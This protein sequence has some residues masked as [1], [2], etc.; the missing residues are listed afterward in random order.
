MAL[1]AFFVLLLACA[2]GAG[3]MLYADSAYPATA[4][5]VV[6]PSGSGLAS[7]AALLEDRGVVR[8]ARA[9]EWY[10]RMHGGADRIQA[11]AYDFAP[12]ETVSAVAAVLE[13]GGRPPS[14][15]VTIPEGFTAEQIGARL[16]AAHLVTASAFVDSVRRKRLVLA[17]EST[18]G[19]EGFLFPDTYRL[20]VQADVDAIVDI[21]TQRFLSQL[22]RGYAQLA[23]A[24]RLTVPQVVTV[25]SMIER[26]AKVDAE[27][28]LIA[29]VIYNRLRLGMPLEID[30]TIEYALPHHKSALSFADLALDSPY[31]T[32][33]HAGL[34]PTP[35]SNPGKASLDAAFRPASTDYLYYVY[36]GDGRHAFSQTL[37]QQQE[38]E[39]RYLR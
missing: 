29:S 2:A 34:P 3:W 18:N 16:A 7:I 25:A 21:M 9:L 39:R 11:A 8:N 37:Q 6:V 23:R 15:W 4:V 36:K 38:N 19:L 5:S 32:Y 1:V 20:P 33:R 14:I 28:P 10:F 26:E 13:A 30:A 17:G 35:I 31:N 12:H 24:R 22:P 27:R